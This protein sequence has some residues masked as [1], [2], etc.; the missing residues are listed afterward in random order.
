MGSRRAATP[1]PPGSRLALE[2]AWARTEARVATAE[3]LEALDAATA[4][5]ATELSLERVLQVIVDR[6]RPLVGARY[7][8]LGH[9]RRARAHR[10]L[11]HAR[12][13]RGARRAIGHPPRGHGLL[14]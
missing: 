13:R 1:R 2:L 10:A 8:A 7:A 3:R 14:G 12:H 5:I 9:R 11:H 6:V 4:A